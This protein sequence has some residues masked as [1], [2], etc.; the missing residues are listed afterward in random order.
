[1]FNETLNKMEIIKKTEIHV[2]YLPLISYVK[3]RTAMKNSSEQLNIIK[4]TLFK[5]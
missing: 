3:H 2:H 1:M 5:A 4:P